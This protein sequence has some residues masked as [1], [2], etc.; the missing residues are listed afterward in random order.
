MCGVN[1]TQFARA[2]AVL[3]G[4]VEIIDVRKFKKVPVSVCLAFVGP[5]HTTTDWHFVKL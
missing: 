1:T 4:N 2:N 3:G 5:G